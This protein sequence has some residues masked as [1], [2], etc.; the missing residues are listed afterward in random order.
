MP[1]AKQAAV[2][3]KGPRHARCCL[4]DGI[5]GEQGE[6]EQRCE[7]DGGGC[8]APGCLAPKGIDWYADQHHIVS[9]EIKVGGLGCG[10]V[11]LLRM[12][13]LVQVSDAIAHG[14]AE[15]HSS[16]GPHDACG[17]QGLR[18]GLLGVEALFSKVHRAI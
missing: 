14:D 7:E 6:D 17:D 2:L 3:G 12:N 4:D 5:D 13:Q 11:S 10:L 1:S 8:R 18:D 15:R 9:I 16:H